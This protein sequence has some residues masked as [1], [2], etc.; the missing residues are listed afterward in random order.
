MPSPVQ[1]RSR[2][3]PRSKWIVRA[4]P[5]R[6]YLHSRR[7]LCNIQ[8]HRQR[9]LPKPINLLLREQPVFAYLLKSARHRSVTA[10]TSVSMQPARDV[11]TLSRSRL[12]NSPRC[13]TNADAQFR[14]INVNLVEAT[15]RSAHLQPIATSLGRISRELA[16]SVRAASQ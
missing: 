10:A 5:C 9:V 6:D 12:G 15:N 4:S 3:W 1:D 7:P 16:G 13:G 14:F 11:I 2:R 8:T